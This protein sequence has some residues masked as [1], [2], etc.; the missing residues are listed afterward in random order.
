[1]VYCS[2]IARGESVRASRE[3]I[4]SLMLAALLFIA[5]DS[6][7][8][9]SYV[10]GPSMEPNLH[11]HQALLI[12]RLGFSG[13]SRQAYAA[14]HPL[15]ETAAEGLVPPRGSICTFV[16]PND[17][18][19]ILVKRVIGLPGETVSVRRGTVYIDGRALDE[20]YV[21]FHDRASMPAHLV[22]LDA[23]FVMGDN[24]PNSSD[25]R[26][27]GP[28]PRVNLLGLVVLRYWPPQKMGLLT[29]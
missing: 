12:S 17:P 3:L 1:M 19:R 2:R 22:P 14:T 6:V 16:H 20:P 23:V 15:E 10:D 29:D 4:F 7:T 9:R 5:I 8:V 26:M 25:S 11:G 21:A 28:V 13:F 27:F 24:R 18:K